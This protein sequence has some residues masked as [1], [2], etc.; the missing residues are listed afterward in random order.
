MRLLK[1]EKHCGKTRKEKFE[2]TMAMVTS[3]KSSINA[4]RSRYDTTD[5]P[6]AWASN[7]DRNHAHL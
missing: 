5:H 4:T 2:P 6:L 7:T 1:V 3:T